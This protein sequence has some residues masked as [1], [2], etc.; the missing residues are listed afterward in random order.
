MSTFKSLNQQLFSQK[1]HYANLV[2]VVQAFAI[3]FLTILF[4]L[5]HEG[6][7]PFWT[8]FAS[9]NNVGHDY[10]LVPATLAILTSI[11]GDLIFGG[12]MAW[13]DEK[14][15]NS[16]TFQLIPFSTNQTWLTNLFS[17][18]LACAYVFIIQVL[19][20]WLLTVPVELYEKENVW[21]ETVKEIGWWTNDFWNLLQ[22]LEYIT[23]VAAL[24]FVAVT[25]VNYASK[26]IS[27]Q[28]PLNNTHWL[29]VLLIALIT[30]LGLYFAMQINGHLA[31]L[32][33]HNVV[34]KT[35]NGGGVIYDNPMWLYNLEAI[36]SLIV[37]GGLDLFL[38]HKYW[39]PRR[40]H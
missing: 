31:D 16:Q 39:E 12:L 4:L 24:V 15:N 18:L 11:V 19:A 13:Q 27:E 33:I 17:S 38:G 36:V 10:F 40:D 8:M 37:I 6:Q 30:F 32:Y 14:V 34:F 1:R 21:T 35:K 7:D 9:S 2:L 5:N 22:A 23:V 28:L 20:C 26:I 3:V 25:F 29:R